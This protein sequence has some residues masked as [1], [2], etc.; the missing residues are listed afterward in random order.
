M[1]GITGRRNAPGKNGVKSKD[2][3]LLPVLKLPAIC[4]LLLGAIPGLQNAG[5]LFFPVTAILVFILW[6]EISRRRRIEKHLYPYIKMTGEKMGLALQ[7]RNGQ[8]KLHDQVRYLAELVEQSSDAIV[9]I[10]L[11]GEILSWNGGAVLLYGYQPAETIGKN[12]SMIVPP[13]LFNEE[14]AI[15]SRIKAGEPVSEFETARMRKDGSRVFVSITLSPVK[16]STGSITSVL[17]ITHNISARKEAEQKI[18]QSEENLK[19]VF[20]NAS[21]GFVLTDRQGIVKAV[22]RNARECV[23][24]NPGDKILPGKNIFDFADEARKPYVEKLIDEVL[25]GKSVQYDHPFT[26]KDGGTTWMRLTYNPVREDKTTITGICIS[27]LDITDQKLAEQQKEFD[28]NNLQALINNTKDLMWSVDRNFNLIT[29]NQAF[30]EMIRCISGSAVENGQNIFSWELGEAKKATYEQFYKRAFA[31]EAFTVTEYTFGG[32]DYWA[33]NSFYPIYE[34]GEVVG[35]A[36]FSRNITEQRKAAEEIKKSNDRF[37]LVASATNDIV[38]DWDLRTNSLWWNKNFHSHFGYPSETAADISSWY[39]NIHPDDTERVVTGIHKVIDTHGHFWTDEYRF[40]KADR[41]PACVL[42]CGYILYDAQGNPERMVGAM[43]DITKRKKAEE[44]LTI[45]FN[46]NH[47]LTKRLSAILNTLPANIALLDSKGTIIEVNNAWKNFNGDTCFQGS[48][49]CIG[50]NYLS[51]AAATIAAN[52]QD[53]R[54][55]SSGVEAILSKTTEEFVFEY[56]CDARQTTRWFRMVAAPLKDKEYEG[57]VVMHI[58]ISEL[59]KLEHERLD[60]KLS[61]H[62]KIT[63]AMMRAQEKER[64]ELG[65]ELHDNLCQLLAALKMKLSS[66]TGNND[67]TG[68]VIHESVALLENAINETRHLSHRMLTP[69]FA[70]SSLADALENLVA[71]YTNTKRV[72]ELDAKQQAGENIPAPLKETVYRVAQEQL[73]NIDKYAKASEVKLHLSVS[74]CILRLLIEDNGI[75]FDTGK[76]RS[77]AGLTNIMCNSHYLI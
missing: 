17:G 66:C 60:S 46:E 29:S 30:N 45:S 41:E 52:D 72:V 38:W 57:A 39:N 51:L 69:R 65:R 12:I 11:T 22:N 25:Q 26:N 32:F 63:R 14:Q 56:A 67:N 75:G 20:E 64:D 2:C 3:M 10:S 35:T 37:E 27:G 73:N 53:A 18:V 44:Q 7:D 28:R 42:D 36:C 6:R 4:P 76:K 71:I 49:Y 68:A 23:L 55:V 16:N 1:A 70:E 40:L 21:E 31:G 24:F 15:L 33:E 5:L 48:G 43:L 58:D 47:A 62:K 13:E 50:D 77:G 8:L 9:S 34:A 59:K 19:A 74:K 61:E 54:I